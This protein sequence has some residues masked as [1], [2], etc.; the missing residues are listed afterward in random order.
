MFLYFKA[1]KMTDEELKEVSM[2]LGIYSTIV[3]PN[4][5]NLGN[6]ELFYFYKI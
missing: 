5:D 4:C 2:H 6:G 1:R 3:L